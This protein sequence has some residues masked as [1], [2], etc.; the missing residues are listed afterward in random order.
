MPSNTLVKDEITQQIEKVCH[1]M[2]L[3]LHQNWRGPKF[4]TQPQLVGILLLK[5]RENKSL[6]RFV[7]WLSES[8]WPEWL[9][10]REI[11]SY[12]TIYRALK[13][14]GMEFLRRANKVI[15]NILQTT[16]KAFDG[17]GINMHYRSRHYEKRAQLDYLPNGKLDILGDIEHFL[18][19]DWHFAMKERHDVLGAKRIIKR[20]KLGTNIEFWADKA[21]DCEE[22]HELAHKKG[23]LLLSPTRKSTRK[24]P[25]GRFRKRVN[26][27]IEAKQKYERPKVETIFSILKRV[28]GENIRARLSHMKKREMAWRIMAMNMERVIKILLLFFYFQTIRN[29]A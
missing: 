20:T 8:K 27:L 5:G 14:L 26:S 18:I 28:Y 29:R 13:R 7:A 23:H 4:Y 21:Y 24:R 9:G 16:K 6:R 17:T 12:S 10:L 22:L 25:K 19:E 3:S 11:P 2:Q 15:T 1:S